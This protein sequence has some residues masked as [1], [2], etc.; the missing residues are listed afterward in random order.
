MARWCRRA[1]LPE[2]K[3]VQAV[4]LFW[5]NPLV[6]YNGAWYGRFDTFC[7]AL[8]LAAVLVGPPVQRPDGKRA[9]SP[10]YFG[11]AVA[12]KTFPAFL[13][14]WFIRNG[15]ERARMF[16][17]TA[18]TAFVVSLPLIVLSP[19]E[20]VKSVV[21]YDANKTPTNL[22]W[23]LPLSQMWGK[24]MTRAIGTFVL[25]GFIV[26]LIVLTSLELMEYCCAGFCAFIVFSKVVNEQYLVWVLPF[27][28]VLYVTT[29][30]KPHLWLLLFFTVIGSIVNPFVH[31]FGAQGTMP[32]IWANLSIAFATSAYLVWL[33]RA[34][35]R[36]LADSD[37]LVLDD[38]DFRAP[39]TLRETTP[40]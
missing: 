19:G 5:L 7:V 15:R 8:L 23:L 39:P 17:Y 25:L 28:A 40:S 31:P 35:R 21:L 22:S 12:T 2:S 20:V 27:L 30:K 37:V 11:L 29:R 3:V 9:R 13:L 33:V 14:P 34:R 26:S 16:W 6:L 18:L 1:G 36:E 4:A 24:D 32:T 38:F 10:I